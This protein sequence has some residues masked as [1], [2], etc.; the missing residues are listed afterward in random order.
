MAVIWSGKG[1]QMTSA[2]LAVACHLCG[3]SAGEPC[4]VSTFPLRQGQGTHMQRE[5]MAEAFGFVLID[6]R[7][8]LFG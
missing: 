1:Q 3:A 6:P 4:D 2:G 8:D 7:R 5:D